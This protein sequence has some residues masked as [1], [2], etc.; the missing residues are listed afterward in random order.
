[1]KKGGIVLLIG[2]LAYAVFRGA[3]SFAEN[4]KVEFRKVSIDSDATKRSAYLNLVYNLT[5]A[6]VNPENVKAQVNNLSLDVFLGERR[7]ATIT[8]NTSFV[9]PPK[10][11]ESVMFTASFPTLSLGLSARDIIDVIKGDDTLP[12]FTIKGF[13]QTP[14]GRIPVEQN[15][16]MS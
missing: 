3:K 16:S 5:L 9:I 12:P 1:M 8:R 7:L 6:F 4:L 2:A 10:G 11:S 15:L 13:L 14:L